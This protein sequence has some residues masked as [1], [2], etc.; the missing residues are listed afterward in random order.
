[1]PSGG[2]TPLYDIYIRQKDN[3]TKYELSLED[4]DLTVSGGGVVIPTELKK[5]YYVYV[6]PYQGLIYE[7]EGGLSIE[8][9]K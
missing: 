8:L 1:M 7:P 3:I 5:G 9:N 2:K 6:M 4:P